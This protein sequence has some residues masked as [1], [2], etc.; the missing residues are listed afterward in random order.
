MWKNTFFFDVNLLW[1]KNHY[2]LYRSWNTPVWAI[3]FSKVLCVLHPRW[4]ICETWWNTG[5]GLIEQWFFIAPGPTW[6]ELWGLCYPLVNMGIVLHYNKPLEK[7]LWTSLKKFIFFHRSICETETLEDCKI[8][9]NIFQRIVDD[10]KKIAPKPL[11]FWLNP[12]V[13]WWFL[14]ILRIQVI[15]WVI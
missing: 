7:S 1:T 11:F 12:A 14:Q 6:F 15:L 3:N 8:C 4:F 13:T 9:F 2:H 5:I 10:V